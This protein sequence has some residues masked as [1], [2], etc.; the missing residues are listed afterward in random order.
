MTK[1]ARYSVFLSG[2]RP[3]REKLP[4]ASVASS[5]PATG[6]NALDPSGLPSKRTFFPATGASPEESWPESMVEEPGTVWSRSAGLAESVSLVAL[7]TT[8]SARAAADSLP[9]TSTAV[10]R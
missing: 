6:A 5:P 4:P 1:R 2:R 10:T 8:A 9:A 7:G 3:A